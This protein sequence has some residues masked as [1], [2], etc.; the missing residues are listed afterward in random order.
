[1]KAGNSR[2]DPPT[3]EEATVTFLA[4]HRDSVDVGRS[5]N[6]HRPASQRSTAF[7]CES[8]ELGHFADALG[9][10]HISWVH[11]VDDSIIGGDVVGHFP[12]EQV[13]ES[14]GSI[15]PGC[16]AEF[17]RIIER[18]EDWLI[19]LFRIEWQFSGQ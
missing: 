7:R 17:I 16:V 19:R 15:V 12:H 1:M 5:P 6:L 14:L 4:L 2:M 11:D 10:L 13:H 8:S 18:L 3:G 9:S